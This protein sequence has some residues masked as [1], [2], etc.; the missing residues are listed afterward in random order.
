MWLFHAREGQNQGCFVSDWKVVTPV[1]DILFILAYL[2][3]GYWLVRLFLR[4][5]DKF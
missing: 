3:V 5:F 4:L 1:G 2:T